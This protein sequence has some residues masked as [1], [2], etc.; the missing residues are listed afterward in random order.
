MCVHAYGSTFSVCLSLFMEAKPAKVPPAP[1]EGPTEK[2]CHLESTQ[3][4]GCVWKKRWREKYRKV[5]RDVDRS[6]IRL[7]TEGRKERQHAMR[8]NKI[9]CV[10]VCVCECV[11]VCHCV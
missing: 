7:R 10:F 5:V 11:C 2:T 6:E 8:C 1:L 3:R 4:T 9:Q